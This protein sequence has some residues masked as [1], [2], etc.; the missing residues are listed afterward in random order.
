MDNENE[1]KQSINLSKNTTPEIT[2]VVE[3]TTSPKKSF[4]KKLF[5]IPAVCVLIVLATSV[6]IFAQSSLSYVLANTNKQIEK[7]AKSA[8]SS[9]VVVN[10][11]STMYDDSYVVN[12]YLDSIIN[13]FFG[14]TSYENTIMTAEWDNDASTANVFLKTDTSDKKDLSL[15][16]LTLTAPDYKKLSEKAIEENY[17]LLKED[18][19]KIFKDALAS[20]PVDSTIEGYEK[21]YTF[22]VDAYELATAFSKYYA[23]T[24]KSNNEI[25][26]NL[27]FELNKVDEEIAT[28]MLMPLFDG[29]DTEYVK[30]SITDYNNEIDAINQDFK[31]EI[32]NSLNETEY[33]A[34]I[35]QEEYFGDVK[36]GDMMTVVIR[37]KDSKVAAMDLTIYGDKLTIE[38]SDVNAYLQSEY[39]LTPEDESFTLTTDLDINQDNWNIEMKGDGDEFIAL[40]WDLKGNKDNFKIEYNDTYNQDAIT[41]SVYGDESSVVIEEETFGKLEFLSK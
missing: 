16:L 19:L 2:E 40:T 14:A 35:L 33:T 27:S 32:E 31:N 9:N 11:M 5:I 12:Y 23:N 22:E 37:T 39:K 18:L 4:S 24:F 34:E 21:E 28:D 38:I 8:M 7:E 3:T 25:Y 13:E 20:K 6:A 10:T 17:K 30:E 41:L 1:N 15:N 26:E 36:K 29:M